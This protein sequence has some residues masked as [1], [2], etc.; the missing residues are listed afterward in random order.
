MIHAS[1]D[2]FIPTRKQG[3]QIGE[4]DRFMERQLLKCILHSK[5]L[6]LPPYTDK[7]KQSINVLISKFV[8]MKT[9]VQL[10]TNTTRILP[11]WQLLSHSHNK[12]FSAVLLLT[13]LQ[14]KFWSEF[15][16]VKNWIR[17]RAGTDTPLS[18]LELSESYVLPRPTLVGSGDPGG[19]TS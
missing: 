4:L 18:C 1:C 7:F 12:N 6:S 11:F 5:P 17:S 8:R 16:K 9:G 15:T 10:H 19:E 13:I 14:Q 2:L 3:L